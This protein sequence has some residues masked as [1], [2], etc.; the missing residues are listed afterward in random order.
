MESI[1]FALVLG[2]A[3]MHAAWNAVVKGSG[4]PLISIALVTAGSGLAALLLLPFIGW[5]VAPEAWL[6]IAGSALAHIL[7]RLALVRGYAIGDMSLVYP[8]AA[9]RR[10]SLPP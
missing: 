2:G 1:V 7:Y 5:T 10:R 8:I 3:V 4:D 6:W 9:D